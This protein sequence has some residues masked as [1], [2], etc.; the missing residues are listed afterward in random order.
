MFKKSMNKVLQAI[1][2]LFT[3]SERLDREEK[4][5]I[6]VILLIL[7]IGVGFVVFK[8]YAATGIG[9]MYDLKN[10]TI[11]GAAA[12]STNTD[13]ST[14]KYL[15]FGSGTRSTSAPSTPNTPTAAP[16]P[17]P[18]PAPTPMPTPTPGG[19]A[20]GWQLT[21]S[22]TGLGG[23]G[24][25]RSALPIFTGTI[26]SGM[27]ISN[28][29]ITSALD[30]SGLSNVTLNRVWIV[31]TSAK[32]MVILG[33]NTTI[34]DSDIDG[35]ALQSDGERVGLYTAGDTGN[36]TISRVSI[37]G[38]T[39]GAWLDGIGTSTGTITDMYIGQMYS[40]NAAHLDGLTRRAGSARLSVTRSHIDDSG[41]FVTGAFFIQNTWGGHIGGI[42][43]KDTFLEGDGYVIGTDDKDGTGIS[44]GFDNV[45]VRSTG[46][47][48]IANAANT[49]YTIWNNVLMYDASRLPAA[50]GP[51]I[52]Y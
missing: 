21:A 41:S 30:L 25:N 14:G 12:V 47:G 29:K 36:Y 13:S 37:T 18:T 24:V 43:L 26:T 16:V 48:P 32:N 51:P 46:W 11:S 33:N 20:Y 42:T 22:N 3:P 35:S 15:S 27:T 4:S 50:D 34:I 17:T 9:L 23:V 38:M 19:V 5:V 45:R 28:V 2:K 8:A 31:P 44:I 10:A 49:Q 52:N 6:G 40:N 39:I 1:R 7:V